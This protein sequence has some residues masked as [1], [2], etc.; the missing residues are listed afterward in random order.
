MR[1]IEIQQ[2]RTA[3]GIELGST[4]IKAVLIGFDDHTPLASG[5]YDWENQLIDGYWTYSMEEV[6]T[7][8][9]AAY[10]SLAEEVERLYEVQLTTV[11]S[12]GFSAMMHGYLPF[13]K[14]GNQLTAFRTWR[15]TST[16]QA[17][18]ALT[19]RFSFNI[20]QRWSIAHLYQAVLNQEEHVKEIDYLTT[21]AGYVHW[22]LTGQ[23]VMGVGEA[24]GMFPI[25]S[26]TGTFHA[27]MIQQ[28]N[29][30]VEFPWKV[31][32]I[33][34]TV[35]LAG[36]AA[37]TLT[38][39]G[40]KLLDPTGK[41]Q[42]GIPVAPPEGDAGTGMT[43]T[44]SVAERIGNV[45]A[46]TSDFA[47]VV[48]EK[49]LEKVH[50]EIDMV[51]TPTGKPVAMVHCNNFTS[52]I[53]AW[54]GLFAE[55]L[56]TMGTNVD[57]NE[58]FTT[59]F[60]KAMEADAD[61]GGLMNVNY[62]SGEPIT[63]FEEGR[64]LFVRK[65]DSRLTLANFMR[66]HIYSALATLKIGM[67][68]LTKEEKVELERLLGHGGF[69]KTERVGQQMMADAMEA[70]VSVMETAGEGGPWGMALLAAYLVNKKSGQALEDYLEQEVFAGNK[71]T[72]I[73]PD[74]KGVESF[75]NF[76]TGY[77]QALEIERTAVLKFR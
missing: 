53:N 27:E 3:L 24:S 21:L 68:I 5:S 35:L 57:R 26:Q 66:T 49:E 40:A 36:E 46:G 9:Q 20:P 31:E 30:L 51:T 17:A 50:M 61:L 58:L 59:L 11:G 65:P 42:A 72:T 25:D 77:H 76:M 15:N 19:N 33:L 32:E 7:G 62:F 45:S 44:N 55:L 28:F 8:L 2:G 29:E 13:D 14:A 73:H 64:P 56:Q 38:V 4:R 18:V 39:E 23:K 75:R 71:G 70:P 41:L 54:A 10:R 69:F 63:G 1:K 16:E 37:G 74:E 34:P 43:A 22:K 67:D 6:W 52:D 60:E 12:I 48:L 47:M